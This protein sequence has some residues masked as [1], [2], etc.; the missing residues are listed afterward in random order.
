MTTIFRIGYLQRLPLQTPYTAVAAALGNILGR[1]PR[2]TPLVVDYSGVGRGIYDMLV[3]YGL[4]PVGITITGGDETHWHGSNR[5]TVPKATLVSNLVRLLHAGELF[6]HGD[7]AE[8]PALRRELQ[9]FR[10]EVTRSGHETWNAAAG[11]HDDLLI[12]ASL[13]AWHQQGAQRPNWGLWE[14]M[15]RRVEGDAG[16]QFCIAA[17]IGQAKDPTAICVMSRLE[18]ATRTDM[19]ETPYAPAAA[20]QYRPIPA[21]VPVYQP[22]S[23]EASRTAAQAPVT[24]DW[25]KNRLEIAS[26]STP[27]HPDAR[28]LAP[29]PVNGPGVQSTYAIGSVEWRAEQAR[30]AAE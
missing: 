15:R 21:P 10:P 25:E 6:V 11:S 30:K 4:Q 14:A 12:A 2:H 16:E 17:D 19:F 29:E 20:W 26:R 9:N 27:H 28:G 1:L 18:R 7:L 24:A 23:V 22:G 3:D 13:A 5:A 8:W